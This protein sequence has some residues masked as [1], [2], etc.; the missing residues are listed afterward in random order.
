[1]STRKF[2]LHGGKKGAAITVRV[3]PRASRNE[4]VEILGDGTV[5]IRITSSPM[6]GEANAALLEFLS[7]VLG[8][9]KSRLEIVAGKSGKDKLISI[10]DVDKRE[11]QDRLL[12]YLN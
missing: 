2:H 9:T 3:T 6:D 4:I 8:V 11:V 5:K 1:M 12:A 7:E 10:L